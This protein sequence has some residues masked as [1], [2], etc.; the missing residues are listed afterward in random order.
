MRDTL[1][2]RHGVDLNGP[3]SS[4]HYTVDTWLSCFL[5]FSAKHTQSIPLLS[6]RGWKSW[7][8]KYS[9]LLKRIP[10]SDCSQ[11]D[12]CSVSRHACLEKHHPCDRKLWSRS[13]GGG[14]LNTNNNDDTILT[15]MNEC[16]RIREIILFRDEREGVVVSWPRTTLSSCCP[17]PRPF[18]LLLCL[19]PSPC[20]RPLCAW[21]WRCPSPLPF[22]CALY[23]LSMS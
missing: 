19:S 4:A 14:I 15:R 23:P 10:Y 18:F 3:D 12:F 20:H 8:M 22:P 1:C 6:H 7:Q 17:S 2:R 9:F 21:W 13:L 16:I 5:S 11:S